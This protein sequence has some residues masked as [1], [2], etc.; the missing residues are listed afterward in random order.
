MK[1]LVIVG[2]FT[3]ANYVYNEYKYEAGDYF[4]NRKK[5]IVVSILQVLLILFCQY[6]SF[7]I[8]TEDGASVT[9]CDSVK[10][11]SG[12]SEGE[13]SN[14]GTASGTK[15]NAFQQLS[16]SDKDELMAK[17]YDDEERMMLQFGSLVTKTCSSIQERIPIDVF[18]VSVLSLKA[19]EPALGEGDQG[20]LGEHSG[21][22]K[23]AKSIANIFAI[24]AP[25]MNYLNY[26]ILKYIIKEHG[27]NDDRVR[28]KD[29][30]KKLNEF[31]GRRIFEVPLLE[32]GS[33]TSNT[34]PNQLKFVIKFD[35]P[36]GITGKESLQ[37]RKQVAKILHVKLAAFL[38]WRVDKGCVQ[39]TF[40]VPKFVAQKMFPLS[41]EQTT[42]LHKDVSVIRLECGD[43]VFEVCKHN[44]LCHYHWLI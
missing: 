18:R 31:C 34:C 13:G 35:I 20:L 36:K 1:L 15:E 39:I 24:L 40:L 3:K 23:A 14:A 19:Y 42:V 44:P 17:L 32:S 6:F 4:D 8:T 25:Y 28:Q 10:F 30:K 2:H 27:T 43:Y 38:I 37:I 22:I 9:N 16:S 12:L 41:S 7:F 33:D 26:E 29:Y 21:E 11:Q 5:K